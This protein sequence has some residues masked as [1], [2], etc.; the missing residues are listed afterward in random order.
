MVERYPAMMKK[1]IILFLIFLINISA[2]DISDVQT[3]KTI[4]RSELQSAAITRLSDIYTL[5]PDLDFYTIDGYRHAPINNLIFDNGNFDHIIMV[6]GVKVD[7]NYW[8]KSNINHLPIHIN[9]IDSII[10]FTKPI[11]YKGELSNNLLVDIITSKPKSGLNLSYIYSSANETGDP[12][13]YRYTEYISHNVD[14]V[15][16]DNSFYINY[17][18]SKFNGTFT[19]VDHVSPA[20]DLEILNRTPNWVFQNIQ[21]RL[22]GTSLRA[23]LNSKI[24][25]HNLFASFTKTG[26]AVLGSVYGA[27]LI[28][29][30]RFNREIPNE[31]QTILLNLSNSIPISENSEITLDFS[32]N[33]KEMFQSKLFDEFS[34]DWKENNYQTKL[35]FDKQISTAHFNVG[36]NHNYQAVQS[37]ISS[38]RKSR[39]FTSIYTSWDFPSVK[40]LNHTFDLNYKIGEADNGLALFLKNKFIINSSTSISLNLSSV[41]LDHSH[42]N[43]I[44]YWINRGYNIPV[45][46]DS[47]II[48]DEFFNKG[49]LK[50][51][52]LAVAYKINS[53]AEITGGTSL[54]SYTGLYS[55]YRF[56]DFDTVNST[57]YNNSIHPPEKSN[58]SLT[59]LFIQFSDQ[60]TH[61]FSHRFSYIYRTSLF[62]NF[63]FDDAI[64][65]LSSHRIFYSINYK[66]FDDIYFGADANYSTATEWFNFRQIGSSSNDLYNFTVP[67]RVVINIAASKTFYKEHFKLSAMVKNLLNHKVQ[68]H[69][70][71]STFDM[72]FVL[73]L[74]LNV[75]P[76]FN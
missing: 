57:I 20:T 44:E 45:V 65:M 17:G 62:N 67:N 76:L 68:Y 28:F 12:G 10:I 7:L 42:N 71:G 72:M 24:G 38:F 27:D 6:N 69:P 54:D 56:V 66:P 4:T 13:P 49:N 34:F 58:G 22:F 59:S 75:G 55:S 60:L 48:F 41:D 51:L 33:Q 63:I 64:D 2:Q 32:A 43:S 19:V 16:P 15:G 70:L 3:A 46:S 1:L 23:N 9:Q 37:K 21:V 8:G 40:K 52:Q 26:D 30:D 53:H 31:N 25:S 73:K 11:L 35:Q 36:V 74:E 5:I 29:I 47:I 39:N 14:Q 18:S 50:S 61:N